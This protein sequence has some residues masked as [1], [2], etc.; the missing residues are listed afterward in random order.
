MSPSLA[1]CG[2]EC[3]IVLLLARIKAGVL[4][5]EDVALVHGGDR[6]LGHLADAV[7]DELHR[8]L[9]HMGDLG[10]DR[11]ERELRVAF[12]LGPA[13]MREQ[14]HLAVGIGDLG[15]GVGG[16]LDAGGVGDDAVFDRYVEVDAHQ[17]AQALHVD[18]V[19]GAEFVHGISRVPDA[20]QRTIVRSARRPG[21]AVI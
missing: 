12:A 3:G 13:E 17:H 7:V 10:G 18:M 11:L 2:D 4:Q 8:P 1:S 19:E 9:E 21:R 15:D 20:A 6:A 14:D 16:A 5:A